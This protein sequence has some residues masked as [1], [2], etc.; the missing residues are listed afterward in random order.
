MIK[1]ILM[2]TII[3]VLLAV[4]SNNYLPFVFSNKKV[5]IINF[6]I[7]GLIILCSILINLNYFLYFISLAL[8]G[9]LAVAIAILKTTGIVMD[10]VIFWLLFS[11]TSISIIGII[12]TK[13]FAYK[14]FFDQGELGC[15][16]PE[17]DPGKSFDK[18]KPYLLEIIPEKCH[19]IIVNNIDDLLVKFSRENNREY[20]QHGYLLKNMYIKNLIKKRCYSKEFLDKI[21]GISK[22]TTTRCHNFNN[23]DKAECENHD[24]TWD[25]DNSKC[26]QKGKM[27]CRYG[28]DCLNHSHHKILKKHSEDNHGNVCKKSISGDKSPH[29][30][31]IGCSFKGDA[32]WCVMATDES[33]P[34]RVRRL[35]FDKDSETF[36]P[37]TCQSDGDCND[38]G[39]KYFKSETEIQ[40]SMNKQIE[41]L[42]DEIEIWILEIL[43]N[44]EEDNKKLL[45][46]LG[47]N[48]YYTL[49]NILNDTINDTELLGHYT[50]DLQIK[51]SEHK[52]Y[53]HLTQEYKRQKIKDGIMDYNLKLGTNFQ[54]YNNELGWRF[55]EDYFFNET[56]WG[57][58]TTRQY[59]EKNKKINPICF[60]NS[61]YNSEQVGGTDL[62]TNKDYNI[63]Y[64]SCTDSKTYNL[65][66]SNDND[67]LDGFIVEDNSETGVALIFSDSTTAATAAAANQIFNIIKT[68]KGYILK[69]KN[70]NELFIEG[71]E[72]TGS[73][74]DEYELKI[75][76][77]NNKNGTIIEFIKH[78]D[79]L[80]RLRAYLDKELNIKNENAIFKKG[81]GIPLKF[82]PVTN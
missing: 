66:T 16:G 74:P 49:E 35:C 22:S 4:M 47:G 64:N 44:S 78:G 69:K 59:L 79:S 41:E 5:L 18:N 55:L 20:N 33:L 67:N 9:T 71:N 75:D 53:Q 21:Y 10:N 56:Y 81:E 11:I 46:K 63:V 29:K 34:C 24:C 30:C 62:Y 50:P 15:K 51:K 65:D 28:H 23:T 80:Y 58:G 39:Y 60:I 68:D 43:R 42:Q 3:F 37:N 77:T 13:Y 6:I 12:I 1:I 8:I 54:R 48:D 82:K 14:S 61:Y 36:T 45:K 31:P 7:W 25:N 27:E 38:S 57:N 32:P 73:N 26:I 40:L 70:G 76:T 19:K 52:Y 17:G 2:E 72:G